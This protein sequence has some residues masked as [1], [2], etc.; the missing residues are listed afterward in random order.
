LPPV[1]RGALFDA[2]G[3]R[4]RLVGWGCIGLLIVT[5][6]LSS[7]YRG[8]SWENPLSGSYVASDVGWLLALTVGL[9]A[10]M[11]AISL[12]H[13]LWLGPASSRA[14]AS[15]DTGSEVVR[16]RLQRASRWTARSSLVLA[17]VVVALAVA[18]VRGL[19]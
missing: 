12:A 11:V 10:L 4:F 1:E 19:P 16:R 13:D 14:L 15:A 2:I 7:V 5:G 6:T 17:L 8:L 3:R 9:V 18:L